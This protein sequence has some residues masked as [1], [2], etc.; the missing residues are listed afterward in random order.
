[1]ELRMTRFQLG[2]MLKNVAN[3][4]KLTAE[5]SGHELTVD[6]PDDL[7]QIVGDRERIEP[8]CGSTS[9]PTQSST[10]PAG[11]HIRLSARAVPRNRVRITVEDDGRGHPGGR[12]A[13]S[14]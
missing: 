2:D 3:A 6:T 7:P 12:R 11:G 10:S 8:G 1:M 9:C 5:D 4:M 14:V 13:A